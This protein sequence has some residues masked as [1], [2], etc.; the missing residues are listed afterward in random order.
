LKVESWEDESLMSILTRATGRNF[1]TRVRALV[2]TGA[3]RD[4][5]NSSLQF[6]AAMTRPLAALLGLSTEAVA[7]RQY[8]RVPGPTATVMFRGARV[9]RHLVMNGTRRVAP[10]ALRRALYHRAVW[11]LTAL[12]VCPDTGDKLLDTCPACGKRL[13]WGGSEV[14][15]CQ[16]CGFDLRRSPARIVPD[17]ALAGARFVA[18]LLEP[19]RGAQGVARSMLAP[20]FRAA[21]PG[22]LVNALLL[23]GPVVRTAEG[24]APPLNWNAGRAS[25]SSGVGMLTWW[26]G[27]RCS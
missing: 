10:E 17:E 24:V 14:H 16:A 3:R 8:A 2:V 12:D 18:D 15:A 27:C 26:P 19:A 1:H 7:D 6:D 5:W 4:I 20:E 21:S 11:D 22:D 25:G 23:L 9:P 13:R